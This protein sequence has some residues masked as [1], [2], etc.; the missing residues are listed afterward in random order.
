[1]A[2]DFLLLVQGHGYEGFCCMNLSDHSKSIFKQLQEL[3]ALTVKLKHSN[4]GSGNWF[5]S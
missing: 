4:I 1:A 5:A 3:K 2:I